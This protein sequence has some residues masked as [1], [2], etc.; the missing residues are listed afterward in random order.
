[1]FDE[2]V[3]EL[4][5]SWENHVFGGQVTLHPSFIDGKTGRGNFIFASIQE[6]PNP[7]MG[8]FSE[9]KLPGQETNPR[10]VYPVPTLW[11]S[12]LFTQEYWDRWVPKYGPLSLRFP[13]VLRS[14]RGHTR[15]HAARRLRVD[16]QVREMRPGLREGIAALTHRRQ[17]WWDLRPWY[18]KLYTE[19]IVSP[20]ADVHLRV[21]LEQYLDAHR[22]RDEVRAQKAYE[23]IL[24]STMLKGDEIRNWYWQGI[25]WLMYLCL[26]E[27]T[28][29][30]VVNLPDPQPGRWR[31]SWA[32]IGAGVGWEFE[33]LARNLE[34]KPYT[35]TGRHKFGVFGDRRHS[36]VH[37]KKLLSTMEKEYP[38]NMELSIGFWHAWALIARTIRS[39]ELSETDW[40]EFDYGMTDYEGYTLDIGVDTGTIDANAYVDYSGDPLDP[41][42]YDLSSAGTASLKG[43][44]FD[45]YDSDEGAPGVRPVA[46][47][48]KLQQLP[49]SPRPTKYF[50]IGEVGEHRA[51][52]DLW[53][54]CEDDM[55]GFDVYDASGELPL[56][57]LRE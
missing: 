1:M 14:T 6:W 30:A 32:A 48:A 41:T 7:E 5:C 39:K 28:A 36:I 56:R 18:R 42:K 47:V 40:I 51:H 57:S 50:T 26:P 52:N 37:A 2:W 15:D 38:I 20:W 19:W 46:K 45:D 34:T 4:G 35:L 13:K 16:Y 10:Q 11:V 24:M 55:S 43:D 54:L 21:A 29:E 17:Q 23:E 8:N 31:R 25:G 3:R 49:Y 44:A 53:L 27:R 22:A 33:P 9:K 12:S